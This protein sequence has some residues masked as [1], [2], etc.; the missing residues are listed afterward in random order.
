MSKRKL[1]GVVFISVFTLMLIW[2]RE[3]H[4]KLYFI[5]LFIQDEIGY[6]KAQNYCSHYKQMNQRNYCREYITEKYI[7]KK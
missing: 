2:P 5:S 4:P 3:I 1:F 6:R 7:G